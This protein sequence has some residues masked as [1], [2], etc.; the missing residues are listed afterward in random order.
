MKSTLPI[1]LCLCFVASALTA[2]E[3]TARPSPEP[4]GG[5]PIRW[6]QP[7]P[8]PPEPGP[9][10]VAA[11][12]ASPTAAL[13]AKNL[14]S[15]TG[16]QALRIIDGE[17]RLVLGGAERVVIPGAVLGTDSVKSITPGRIVLTRRA[18]ESE[19]GDA[20]VIVTFDAL[21]RTRVQVFATKDPTARIPAE[22]K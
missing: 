18:P 11:P 20:F 6:E 12:R 19:G 15:L 1:T 13:P 5:A 10:T 16:V 8:I 21:G 7:K 9:R 17:A 3:P 14:G 2:Q 22:V 4:R